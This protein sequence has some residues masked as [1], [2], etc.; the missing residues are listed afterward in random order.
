MLILSSAQIFRRTNYTI[1]DFPCNWISCKWNS[2]KLSLEE[3]EHIFPQDYSLMLRETLFAI[4][5]N[6]CQNMFNNNWNLHKKIRLK[7]KNCTGKQCKI[8]M[9]KCSPSVFINFSLNS[10]LLVQLGQWVRYC[11][12][13]HFLLHPK[14]QCIGLKFNAVNYSPKTCKAS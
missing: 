6:F 3:S 14:C 1:L 12:D 11:N 2:I 8:M 10:V 9:T 5:F 4:V 7:K 13:G